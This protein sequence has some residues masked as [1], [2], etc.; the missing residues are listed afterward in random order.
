V[1]QFPSERL[2]DTGYSSA[3]F[4]FS[5]FISLHGLVDMPLER[6]CFFLVK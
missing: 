4:D 5:D 1:I 6:G 2:G 3:M